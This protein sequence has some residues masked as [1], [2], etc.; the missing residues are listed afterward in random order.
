MGEAHEAALASS[1]I[2]ARLLS[3]EY[4]IPRGE[5]ENVML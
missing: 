5:I 1:T 2:F 3:E 4:Y